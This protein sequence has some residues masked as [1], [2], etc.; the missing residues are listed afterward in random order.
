MKILLNAILI[1]AAATCVV[2]CKTSEANY[3]AAYEKAVAAR[4]SDEDIDS[5]IYGEVRRQMTTQTV[6]MPDGRSVQ[7]C[8]QFV[9]VT[10]GGGGIPENLKQFNVVAGQFKQLFNAKSLRDRLTDLGYPGAF[11]VETAEPYYYVVAGS[12]PTL[13]SATDALEE[14]RRKSPVAMKAPLP[15]ILDAARARANAPK[16]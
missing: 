3:R 13:L 4:S 10:E 14:L 7:V 9:R 16:R 2:G 5:T 6:N 8:S 12:Y 11:V 15:F 1:L